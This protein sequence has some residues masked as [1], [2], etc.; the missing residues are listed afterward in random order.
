MSLF[1]LFV[2]F[3]TRKIK[4]TKQMLDLWRTYEGGANNN[5]YLLLKPLYMRVLLWYNTR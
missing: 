1:A 4:I 3:K 2:R 5:S